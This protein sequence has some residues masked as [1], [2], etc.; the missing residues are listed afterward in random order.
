M[1]EC[2]S[3][4][5]NNGGVKQI[6]EFNPCAIALDPSYGA[7]HVFKTVKLED[8]ILIDAQGYV[9]GL[10]PASLPGNILNQDTFAKSGGLARGN[11]CYLLAW[12]SAIQAESP[13]ISHCGS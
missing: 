6:V 1:W 13:A 7:E 2:A 8:Q 11:H 5:F 12:L 4:V 10:D 9:S 3:Q